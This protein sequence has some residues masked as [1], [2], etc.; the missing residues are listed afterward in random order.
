MKRPLLVLTLM[1]LGLAVAL[2]ATAARADYP[3][4]NPYPTSWELKFEHQTP[5]RVVVKVP[6]DDTPKAYWYMTYTITNDSDKERVFFPV[7]TLLYQDGEVARSDDKLGPQVFI[8]IKAQVKD[9]FLENAVLMGGEIRLG[10]D[11]GRDGVAIWPEVK[12]LP[13]GM[14]TF[15]IFISG[16]SG[17][18][19]A[20]P[21]T[22]DDGTPKLDDQGHQMYQTEKDADGKDQII[23][24]WKTLELTYHINGDEIYPGEDEVNSVGEEWIM[25]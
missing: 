13:H 10:P 8:A 18:W 15:N 4:P 9:K 1:T 19:A 20:F 5:H 24:L 17:E 21:L 23:R 11:E 2:P 7:L 16:I 12:N 6:G 14:G 3:K 25:R 22:N